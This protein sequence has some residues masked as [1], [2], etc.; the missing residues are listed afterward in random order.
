MPEAARDGARDPNI[1][2][3]GLVEEPRTLRPGDLASLTR[4]DL[5]G[6]FD[7]EEGRGV[8]CKAQS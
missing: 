7:C 2:L 3:E 4:V 1:R 6:P 5:A 8:G